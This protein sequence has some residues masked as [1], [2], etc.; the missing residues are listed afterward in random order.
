MEKKE[1]SARTTVKAI[2]T[3]FVSYGIIRAVQRE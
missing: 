2:I 1:I 3:G